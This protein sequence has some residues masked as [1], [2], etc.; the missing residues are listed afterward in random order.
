MTALTYTT[1]SGGHATDIFF[2]GTDSHHHQDLFYVTSDGH[3][4]FTG[5]KE[6][7]ANS[8]EG[9]VPL[10]PNDLTVANG[11]LY[12]AGF[13]KSAYNSSGA[14]GFDATPEGLWVY[15]PKAGG[16]ANLVDATLAG[17]KT[18][19]HIGFSNYDLNVGQNYN[20]Q[21]HGPGSVLH[22]I[23]PQP[24]MAAIGHDIFFTAS[25]GNTIAGLY[26]YD[27]ATNTIHTHIHGTEG[28]GPF[29]LY[30]VDL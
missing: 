30:A 22:T 2:N 18:K 14:S 1:K 29:N 12:F 11:R 20:S 7:I 3:G 23:D 8:S 17:T 26:E 24:Q 25:H 10:F 16:K 5:P 21:G 19:E 4:G 6:I 27:T 13:E 15:D 28:A 9:A